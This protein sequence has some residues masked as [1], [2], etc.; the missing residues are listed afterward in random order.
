MSR[1]IEGVVESELPRG[2]YAVRSSDGRRWT[3]SLPVEAVIDRISGRRSCEACGQVFHVRYNPPPP[4]GKC[5]ACGSD[6]IGQRNDDREEKVRQRNAEYLEK[7]LPLLDFYGQ[8][9][10]V[11][12]I[13]G[14]GAVD[15]VTRRVEAALKVS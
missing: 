3:A 14:T 15:E 13:D 1:E 11:T 2:L 10:V 8:R 5:S 9:G 12:K 4:D 6:R 7:T